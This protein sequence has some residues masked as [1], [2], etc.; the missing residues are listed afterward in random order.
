[1]PP[2]EE[3]PHADVLHVMS[4]HFHKTS[5]YG[6]YR[7][8]G[9]RDWLLIYT[10]SGL[11][12][13]GYPGG[14]LI[15]S[16]G[17]WVLLRP[18]TLHDYGVESTL[19]QWELLW[20]HF[21]PRTHWLAW[22]NWPVVHGGLMKLHIADAAASQKVLERF[23]D[24]YRLSNGS[25]RQRETF[26]MNALEEVLLWCDHHNPE[27]A[28]ST[29][30][31]RIREAMDFVATNLSKK[32]LLDDIADAVGLSVS[33]LSHLFKAETG[34]SP[35]QYLEHCRIDRAAEMLLRTTF[36]IKQI[37]AAVGF[38]SPFYFSLR[39]KART[40]KSPKAFRE[41]LP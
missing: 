41:S 28:A 27:Q 16:P 9:T 20:A 21:H 31:S 26:A 37:A 14:E 6:A 29:I 22:L 17:D 15:A 25:L 7:T 1:M 23:F 19:K 30:D 5:G 24:V 34:Q 11:G 33:R 39:F 40:K 2:P 38:E 13:F 8:A 3:T 12:R 18:G 35:Q 32:I 36:S 4:D 10:V